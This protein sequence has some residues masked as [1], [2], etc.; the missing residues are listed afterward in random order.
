MG[1]GG[2]AMTPRLRLVPPLLPR[3]YCAVCRIELSALANPEHRLCRQ[4]WRWTTAGNAL[5]RAAIALEASP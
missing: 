1:R 4:C 3:R 2:K 5:K